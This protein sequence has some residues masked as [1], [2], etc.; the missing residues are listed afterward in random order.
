[1]ALVY[2]SKYTPEMNLYI[3]EVC[4]QRYNAEALL[5]HY[6]D[7]QLGTHVIDKR[8][9]SRRLKSL[10]ELLKEHIIK[11]EHINNK[12]D[13]DTYKLTS[14]IINEMIDELGP[15]LYDMRIVNVIPASNNLTELPPL[16]TYE[17]LYIKETG[18]YSG[19]PS[20]KRGKPTAGRKS[21]NRIFMKKRRKLRS[22][23]NT[24]STK[25]IK[26]QTK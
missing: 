3:Y 5:Q 11:G 6:L 8:I 20:S 16:P 15:I 26:K 4:E 2:S 13:Y 12:S 1:M 10:I 22:T 23:R 7:I 17:N 24:R 25:K 19:E 14:T 9:P 21:R 18:S